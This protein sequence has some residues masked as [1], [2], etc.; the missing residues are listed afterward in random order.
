MVRSPIILSSPRESPLAHSPF[1]LTTHGTYSTSNVHAALDIATLRSRLE[2]QAAEASAA[3]NLSF[4]RRQLLA[5][6]TR[7][8]R[9]EFKKAAAAAAAPGA[10]QQQQPVTV[11]PL[12]KKYQEE[13]D[14]LT[15]RAKAA[16]AA[17][18]EMLLGAL[19]QAPDPAAALEAAEAKT[20]AAE[21]R[22]A[23]A[24]ASAAASDAAAREVAAELDEFRR[25]A[26]ALSNQAPTIRRLQERARETESA[27]EAS[28]KKWSRQRATLRRRLRL[29]V[30]AATAG[31]GGNYNKSNPVAAAFEGQ[32]FDC[33]EDDDEDEDEGDSS[34][35]QETRDL[36]AAVATVRERAAAELARAAVAAD[37][38]HSQLLS[39]LDESRAVLAGLRRSNDEAQQA[40]L[41]SRER[42]E[43]ERAAL[44]A[45]AS[46]ARS[47]AA[48]ATAAQAA[49]AVDAPSPAAAS[50]KRGKAECSSCSVALEE[51]RAQ[52]D[53]AA[54]AR[55]AA[56]DADARASAADAAVRAAS[57]AASASLAAITARAEA[58]E[59]ALAT[60][61]SAE[62]AAELEAELEA[63]RAV[64]VGGSGAD[65]DGG[66]DGGNGSSGGGGNGNGNGTS[67]EGQGHDG[68]GCDS[69]AP[70]S[71]LASAFRRK[72]RELAAARVSCEEAAAATAAAT[73]RAEEAEM[74]ASVASELA[75]R[76][77]R[78]LASA[79]GQ[80][81][82]SSSLARGGVAAAAVLAAGPNSSSSSSSSNS[83]NN[84][85]SSNV[86]ALVAAQRDRALARAAELEQ[87]AA[88][89]AEEAR[90]ARAAAEAARS[91]LARARSN[92][93]IGAGALLGRRNNA[94][95]FAF[96]DLEG[97][98]GAASS[99]SLSAASLESPDSYGRGAKALTAR[100][101][102]AAVAAA[103]RAAVAVGR[104]VGKSPRG[105]V[106]ALAYLTAVHLVLTF[107]TL[108]RSHRGA[109]SATAVAAASAATELLPGH[110]HDLAAACSEFARGRGGA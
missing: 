105:R 62:R 91:E 63:L 56:A 92:G 45:E 100:S 106:A 67:G 85:S 17:L 70:Q 48:A 22:A 27:L 36:A 7:E 40:L 42:W 41:S 51:L 55:A 25:E 14:A 49:A 102:K 1:S 44:V 16:E 12:L 94:A 97:G 15:S 43:D 37:E 23:A 109:V 26:S 74:R 86:A 69:F 81:M 77:E 78:D 21:A 18:T 98:S 90:A 39:E 53:A 101:T 93:G 28:K 68:G 88:A 61:P 30:E 65:G 20:A 89:S 19:S 8:W 83:N 64:V 82:S 76:L 52:R 87:Q 32:D 80:E 33:N 46:E 6:A 58:A 95:S 57:E 34:A 73:R 9:A 2:K 96:E 11:T 4:S 24:L 99:S 31:I 47:V 3:A 59:S 5:S 50:L 29:A 72:E 10:A 104:A 71:T 66:D 108:A 107:T 60:R 54:T 38:R 35:E 75:G 110:V 103:D 79:L 13:I 84:N